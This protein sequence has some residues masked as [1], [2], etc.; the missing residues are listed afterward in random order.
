MKS[1]AKWLVSALL[2]AGLFPLTVAASAAPATTNLA[3]SS[4]SKFGGTSLVISG[5]EF[6]DGSGNDNVIAVELSVSNTVTSLSFTVAS[7]TR[8]DA[9]IPAGTYAAGSASIIVSYTAS[10]STTL[11]YNF[12]GSLAT[13]SDIAV[14][15]A[16]G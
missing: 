3:P 14:A 10:P 7:A 9:A 2:A 5:S 4:G 1:V 11:N 13:Q 16:I 12:L 8:V 6:E 15:P